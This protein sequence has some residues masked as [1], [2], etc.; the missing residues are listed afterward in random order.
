METLPC[1]HFII[2]LFSYCIY[3]IYQFFYTSTLRYV[4]FSIYEGLNMSMSQYVNVLICQ[5]LYST[6]ISMA[7][8]VNVF[9]NQERNTYVLYIIV[10]CIVYYTIHSFKGSK[11]QLINQYIYPGLDMSINQYIYPGFDLSIH[12]SRA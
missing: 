9:I 4:H 5:G 3:T 12:I 2:T 8:N 1:Q 11:K 7:H 10:Y 6:Y